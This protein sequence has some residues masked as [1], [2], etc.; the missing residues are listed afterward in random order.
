M[1]IRD[2]PHTGPILADSL[3]DHLVTML[4]AQA[5]PGT[6]H[7]PEVQ[8]CADGYASSE[9]AH[10][11]AAGSVL[12]HLANGTVQHLGPGPVGD[13]RSP[14]RLLHELTP[15]SPRGG[16][17]FAPP[18][19]RCRH[20][21][22]EVW[23]RPEDGNLAPRCVCCSANLEIETDWPHIR[24][25][26]CRVSTT[27]PPHSAPS[28]ATSS[29]DEAPPGGPAASDVPDRRSTT[30]ALADSWSDCTRCGV[31]N[32]DGLPCGRCDFCALTGGPEFGWRFAPEA[33]R[34]ASVSPQASH[35]GSASTP[36]S[37]PSALTADTAPSTPSFVTGTAAP[38]EADAA[39]GPRG[40]E[41][42]RQCGAYITHGPHCPQCRRCRLLLCSLQCRVSHEEQ[43]GLPRT[44]PQPHVRCPRCHNDHAEN[45]PL[46][47]CFLLSLIHI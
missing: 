35:V 11:T 19:T 8:D 13:A 43:C 42:C 25:A 45:T 38:S 44:V 34:A 5:Q 2:S 10:S 33:G 32:A 37:P 15:V 6:P 21:S 28:L 7:R 26:R 18:R 24:C 31:R 20:T 29:S 46:H 9:Y 1:C 41:L 3:R 22:V 16:L 4:R 36:S 39:E 27:A 14:M 30:A 40:A 23:R 47:Y 12:V 17:D